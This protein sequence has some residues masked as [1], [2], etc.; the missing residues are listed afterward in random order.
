[1][2]PKKSIRILYLLYAVY[3]LMALAYA[4]VSLF[5]EVINPMVPNAADPAIYLPL[6]YSEK[7]VMILSASA[8]LAYGV[9][10][11]IHTEG[12]TKAAY[13]VP[14]WFMGIADALIFILEGLILAYCSSPETSPYFHSY[15]LLAH[16]LDP[17]YLLSFIGAILLIRAYQKEDRGSAFLKEGYIGLGFLVPLFVYDLVLFSLDMVNLVRPPLEIAAGTILYAFRLAI[18]IF[19]FFALKEADE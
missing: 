18:L 19:A 11:I 5:A 13:Y 15:W 4:L 10:G 7:G 2:N 8:F 12:R 3:G 1:M 17:M 14:L 6:F 16:F 9:F